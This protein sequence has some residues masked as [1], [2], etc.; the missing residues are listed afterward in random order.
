MSGFIKL[1]KKLIEWEW[2][3]DANTFRVFIYC[4]LKANYK[5]KPWKGQ[6][7]SRGSFVSSP[8]KIGID[9]G[10]SRQKVRTSFDKLSPN[11]L[12]IKPTNKFSLITIVNYGKYQDLPT[13]NLTI[14]Q[15]STNHQ[16]TTTKEEEEVKEVKKKKDFVPPT[17]EEVKSYF[18]EKGF[19]ESL[20]ARAFESY[21]VADW[22]DSKG[23][24]IK[25]WK[26]KMLHVWF[27]DENKVIKPQ[28]LQPDIFMRDAP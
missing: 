20:G 12:T 2:F 3:T 15:P 23:N 27:R 13:S 21:A 28:S 7:I 5:D 6:V 14:N 8:E 10:L 1:H 19:C 26:Q 24:K 22:Y 9:L 16:L 18:V 4:L 17:E 25:N 11:D